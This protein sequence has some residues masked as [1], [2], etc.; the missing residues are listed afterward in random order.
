MLIL[1]RDGSFFDRDDHRPSSWHSALAAVLRLLGL[2]RLGLVRRNTPRSII[3][4]RTVHHNVG[5]PK[6]GM[7]LAFTTTAS[8]DLAGIPAP[9]PSVWPRLRSGDYLVTLDY[10][11]PIK[12]DG[13]DIMQ[14]DALL[15]ELETH[16]RF[17]Y[18]SRGHHPMP[19]AAGQR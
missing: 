15:S 10:A 14:I 1:D 11:Q 5:K 4:L 2:H 9:V 7:T 8:R 13:E 6:T 16:G 19:E 17:H 18:C 12:Y 3:Q